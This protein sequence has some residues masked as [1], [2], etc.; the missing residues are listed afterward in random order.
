M[1]IFINCGSQP[2]PFYRL[3]NYAKILSANKELDIFQ[4]YDYDNFLTADIM[5]MAVNF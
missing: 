4:G 2:I 5:L 3:W 1:K